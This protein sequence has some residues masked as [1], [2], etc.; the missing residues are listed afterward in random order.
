MEIRGN[1]V[2]FG[3]LHNRDTLVH[4]YFLSDNFAGHSFVESLYENDF[5]VSK[6]GK[7]NATKANDSVLKDGRPS[8]KFP[9]ISKDDKMFQEYLFTNISKS[10]EYII[11]Y[12]ENTDNVINFASLKELFHRKG[13]NMRLEWIVYVKL[14]RERVKTLVGADILVRCLKKMLDSKTSKKLSAFKKQSPINYFEA[15]A[16]KEKFD[17]L[18][19]DKN[20]F[21]LE[22]Y[23]KKLLSLYMNILMRSYTEVSLMLF[24]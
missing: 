18:L 21:L 1:V 24:L 16:M 2:I 10:L 17:E 13:V 14:K 15:A 11:D 8:Y 23:Y 20:E 6:S 7:P 9:K 5:N 3:T 12:L 4:P 22:L 19:Q